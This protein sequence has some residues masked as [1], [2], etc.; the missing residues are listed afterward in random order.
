MKTKKIDAQCA[1][2]GAPLI[3][4]RREEWKDHVVLELMPCVHCMEKRYQAGL[5]EENERW[6]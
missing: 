3:V 6:Q 4:A 1:Q 5:Q 2:C